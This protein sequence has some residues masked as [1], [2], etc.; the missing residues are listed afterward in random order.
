MEFGEGEASE[1]SFV[2]A[3]AKEMSGSVYELSRCFS[4][5]DSVEAET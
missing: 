3:S 5:S 2:L 1:N 4:F